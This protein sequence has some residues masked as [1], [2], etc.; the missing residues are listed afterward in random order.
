MIPNPFP[1]I[2][3]LRGPVPL[4][5]LLLR[6][7]VRPGDTAV[8]ATC[9]NGNDTLLLAELVGASGRVW[10]FDIQEEAVGQTAARLAAAGHAGRVE[11][12]RSGHE[13]LAEH[14]GGGVSA[15]VFNLGYL[16]GGDRTV[17]T[18]SET[19]LAALE[20]ALDI[21]KPGGILA[22]TVYPGHDGGGHERRSVDAWATGRD[23]RKF[24]SWRLGQVNVP[25]TAPYLVMIQKAL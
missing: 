15:V 18:R 2:P 25:T 4:S 3:L 19:T 10:A 21:L 8:D 17:I 22:V 7:F 23:P 13:Y 9:G 6:Q 24:H 11:I 5:H 14:V 20:Q 16:P 12:I 1:E